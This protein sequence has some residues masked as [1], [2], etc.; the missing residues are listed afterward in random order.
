MC[1]HYVAW[2]YLNALVSAKS[3]FLAMFHIQFK[4]F[5]GSNIFVTLDNYS[6]FQVLNL[7]KA[8]MRSLIVGVCLLLTLVVPAY[9]QQDAQFTMFMF[10]RYVLNP[11]YAGALKATNITGVG[12]AQWVGVPGAPN[13]ATASINGYM[14]KLHGGLGAYVV[15][16]KLG[17]I[18]TLGV[19]AAYSYHMDF[20][21]KA[22]LNIGVG[23][24]L[25]QKTL[26]GDWIYRIQN[27][28]DPVLPQAPQSII[29]PDLD[30]GIYF[31]V[32]LKGTTSTAYPQDK[33]YIGASVGHILE[34]SMEK[35]TGQVDNVETT[36]SRG[37]YGS[38][39]MTFKLAQ[40][41]FLEPN[42]NYR[43][44]G[45]NMQFDINANLYISP[46]VFGISRRWNDSFAG[47]VGFNAS[48]YLFMGYSY[49]YTTSGLGSFTTGSHELIV[50]YTF[51]SKY[52]NMP[53]LRGNRT[54]YYNEI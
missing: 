34:P 24:G 17:A 49:D 43:M 28:V 1:W 50:S 30:G 5:Q 31:H 3:A 33:F 45:S 21:G 39:G 32:P 41:I 51:P 23:G 16:D 54:L 53:P 47:I 18:S 19:K 10:N 9:S 29:L 52:K 12:R 2:K 14:K 6:Q 35:I 7:F 46:M 38:A 11:A 37:I 8:Y 20:G 36:L 4:S 15:S 40:N 27:G 44:A 26:D 25:Y 13:T 22:G 42:V 48:P